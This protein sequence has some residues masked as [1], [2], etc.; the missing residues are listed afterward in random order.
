MEYFEAVKK[1]RSIRR[2]TDEKVPESVIN[3]ALESALL[4]PNSSNTQ[5]WDFHW[6]KSAEIKSNLIK[7]CF[8]QSAARTASDLIVITANPNLWKRSQ[9]PLV[10]WAKKV[11]A[12]KDVVIYY[13]KLIPMIYRYGF[14]NSLGLLKYFATS[15]I[16]LFR[17]MPRYTNFKR[18]QQEIAIKSAALAA[19]N[20]ALAISAQGFDTC[21]ME[22]FDACRVR[23]I[24]KLNSN[25]RVVMVIAVGKASDQGT[26]GSQMRLPFEKVVHIY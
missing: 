16:G 5:T 8:S 20:F 2:Y 9:K 3:K 23:K 12:P 19:E 17:P 14:L 18:D 4:A 10:D 11:N 6:V 26:W 24:L 22:G 7:A 21:M 13:E 15:I 25:Y 1:R